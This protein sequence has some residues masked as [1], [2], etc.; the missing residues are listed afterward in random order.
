[1][2]SV[3]LFFFLLLP[4]KRNWKRLNLGKFQTLLELKN[5]RRRLTTNIF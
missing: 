5:G 4:R 1:M 3:S 2:G